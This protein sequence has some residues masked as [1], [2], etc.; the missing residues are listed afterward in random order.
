MQK[1]L[2]ALVTILLLVFLFSLAA[3]R[4]W[5]DKA[6][7]SAQVKTKVTLYNCQGVPI[8]EWTG[9]FGVGGGDG[10]IWFYHNGGLVRISGTIIV[11][12]SG[13]AE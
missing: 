3:C 11:E 12:R 7:Q 5:V 2:C 8:R 6:Q 4:Q 13:E 1:R 10:S 9:H